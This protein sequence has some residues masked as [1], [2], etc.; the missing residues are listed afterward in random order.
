MPV[1]DKTVRA[2]EELA[3]GH[4]RRQEARQRDVFLVLAADA[5]LT[6]GQRDQA[7]RLRRRLLSGNPYHLLRPYASFA[8]ALGSP[9]VQHFVAELRLQFPP[10]TAEQMASGGHVT[11]GAGDKP[12]AIVEPEPKIYRLQEPNEPAA[13]PAAAPKVVV[14]APP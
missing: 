13:K 8:E 7:E 6:L 10:E 3:E 2:Y 1:T 9:D 4:A 5:A 14:Q 11:D 12:A